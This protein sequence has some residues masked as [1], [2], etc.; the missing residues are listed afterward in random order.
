MPIIEYLCDML[1]L[2]DQIG[3]ELKLEGAAKRIVS[4]VPSQTELLFDIGLREEVIGITKFCIHPSSWFETKT[5]IGGTKKLN[6]EMI[7]S[8]NPDL[9]IANKEENTKEEIE[10]LQSRFPVYTSDIQTMRHSYHMMRDIGVLT[11]RELEVAKLI[12]NIEN[13]RL[14]NGD[15][16][17][18]QGN[19]LYLIWKN[20]YMTVR[21]DTFIS[22]MLG[23]AGWDNALDDDFDSRY[24]VL[25]LSDM[26]AFNPQ[27]VFLSSEPF[28]F[29]EK[30]VH[31]LKE[32]LPNSRIVVVDGEMFSWYG[33]RLKKSFEYFSNL[34][35]S[36]Y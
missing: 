8:L 15:S 26:I 13:E 11:N 4:V 31:E 16:G 28:P 25:E 30:D 22:H 18:S 1:E 24:P 21:D 3:V 19:A 5:R 2:R 7:Q 9:I 6:L 23:L 35:N 10:W 14:V 27:Y 34:R 33:S 20:P 36:A 12:D 32:I 29:Q 17:K